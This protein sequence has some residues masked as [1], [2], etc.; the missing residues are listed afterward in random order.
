MRHRARA[1]CIRCRSGWH[2]DRP[3]RGLTN[4]QRGR[5]GF[6]LRPVVV[7]CPKS[8]V[9]IDRGII[10]WPRAG[11]MPRSGNMTVNDNRPL[12]RRSKRARGRLRIPLECKIPSNSTS[13]RIHIAVH[14]LSQL[15]T[16]GRLGRAATILRKTA[17]C[18]DACLLPGEGI[19]IEGVP[20]QRSDHYN[21]RHSFHRR[22]RE[23][24]IEWHPMPYQV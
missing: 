8:C 21:I 9:V 7:G 6:R 19:P 14:R 17:S 16:V 3:C 12:R 1:A 5:L 4:G 18:A 2:T 20:F 22:E 24:N 23:G 10:V 13:G 11:G 15:A